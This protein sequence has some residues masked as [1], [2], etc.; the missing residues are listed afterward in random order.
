[1]YLTPIKIIIVHPPKNFLPSQNQN[2]LFWIDNNEIQWQGSKGV[3]SMQKVYKGSMSKGENQI[4][5][6]WFSDNWWDEKIK[7]KH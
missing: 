7:P 2:F 1:M 6:I 3:K 4:C 5:I